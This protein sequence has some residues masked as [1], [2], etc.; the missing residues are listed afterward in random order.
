RAKVSPNKGF[1]Q[2]GQKKVRPSKAAG[3]GGFELNSLGWCTP[4]A[5]HSKAASHAVTGRR[6]HLFFPIP[7]IV[8]GVERSLRPPA[9]PRSA[10][11]CRGLFVHKVLILAPIEV[12]LVHYLGRKKLC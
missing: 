3:S 5:A 1:P 4:G 6:L 10:F 11:F 7:C 9:R 8:W 12:S 2:C